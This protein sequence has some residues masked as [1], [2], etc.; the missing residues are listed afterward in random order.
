MAPVRFAF[1]YISEHF[2]RDPACG[3]AVGEYKTKTASSFWNPIVASQDFEYRMS[4]ILDRPF[5][6][7]FGHRF[8][9]SG[10]L[11]AYRYIAV[12]SDDQGNGPLQEYFR[13]DRTSAKPDERDSIWRTNMLLAEDRMLAFELVKS[14]N[15]AWT[16]MYLV[17][18]LA[19]VDVPT[20]L[21]EFILQQRRWLTGNTFASL[22]ALLNYHKLMVLTSHSILRKLGLSFQFAYKGASMALS[23]FS[24]V[25]ILGANDL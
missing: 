3:C 16:L 24:I 15:R 20:T 2:A 13:A 11:S 7:L 25:R 12:Q 6:S 17:W 8:D 23:W 1:F 5:E 9:S 18:A 22:Y 21:P 19:E 4:F 10:A 14:R